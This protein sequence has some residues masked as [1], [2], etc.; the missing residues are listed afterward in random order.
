MEASQ[1]SSEPLSRST[2]LASASFALL[3][4]EQSAGKPSAGMS[5]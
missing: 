4:F 2:V 3:N 1:Y 5:F